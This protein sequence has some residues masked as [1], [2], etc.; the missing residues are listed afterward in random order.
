MAPKTPVLPHVATVPPTL[1]L[2]WESGYEI[3]NLDDIEEALN[4][5]PPGA[6]VDTTEYRTSGPHDVVYEPLLEKSPD[7]FTLTY[8]SKGHWIDGQAKLHEAD[9]L[10][11]KAVYSKKGNDDKEANWICTW[12]GNDKPKIGIDIPC[13]YSTNTRDKKEVKISVRDARFRNLI[14]DKNPKCIIT[15]EKSENLL[16]AAHIHQVHNEGSDTIDNGFV[17]RSDIHRLFDEH[18]LTLSREG[19]FKMD[20]VPDSY[21]YLFEENG[22]WIDEPKISNIERYQDNI[23]LR[24]DLRQ[25]VKV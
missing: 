9:G 11:G 2:T 3:L 14:F 23:D 22:Q 24:N 1:V 16:Q 18:I 13:K 19:K 15:G 20:P 4:S 21:Q 6:T 17:M 12:F 25:K 10:T 7:G 8:R 5:T